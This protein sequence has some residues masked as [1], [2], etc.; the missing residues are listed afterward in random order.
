MKKIFLIMFVFFGFI[1]TACTETVLPVEVSASGILLQGSSGQGTASEPFVFDVELNESVSSDIMVSPVGVV[2]NLTFSFVKPQGNDFVPLQSNDLTGLSLNN[3]NNNF[4]FSVKAILEGS[5][6]VKISQDDIFVYIRVNVTTPE[7]PETPVDFSKELK[8]LAIGNS[9]SDDGM[10]Y[11]YQIANDYGVDNIVLGN[12]YIG[13]AELALHNTNAQEDKKAYTYRKNTTGSWVST[14]NTSILDG[15]LDEE[16]DIITIQQASGKSG[17]S[18]FFEP[19]LTQLLEYVHENKTNSKAKVYWHMT[20]AYQ[21]TS[22]HSE[23]P[24]Y[25]SDQMTMYN[26]IISTYR[27]AVEPKESIKGVIPAGTAIQNI[28]TSY[29]G[30][31]VTSDGYHLNSGVGRFTAGMTWFKA[32][33]GLSINNIQYRPAGVS[34]SDLEAIKE[35]VNQAVLKPFEVTNST[36]T[37]QSE[38]DLKNHTLVN[39]SLTYVL[40]YWVSDSGHNIFTTAANSVN[41]STHTVRLSKENLPVGSVLKIEPG[42]QYRINYFSSLSGPVT[43]NVRSSNITTPE[44]VIDSQ[45]WGNYEYVGINVAHT[46]AST[47]IS[48]TFV[49]VGNKLSIYAAPGATSPRTTDEENPNPVLNEFPIEYVLGYWFPSTHVINQTAAN[50]INFVASNRRY[51]KEELPIGTVLEIETGYQFRAVMFKNLDGELTDNVR[52]DNL[53][54]NV[55]IDAAFWGD[56]EYVGFNISPNTTTDVTAIVADVASKFKVKVPY[57]IQTPIPHVDQP[58]SFLSGYWFDNQTTINPGV[59]TFSKGFAASNALSKKSLEEF[60]QVTIAA[61]YQVR[62]VFFSYDNFGVYKVLFRTANFTGVKDLDDTFWGTYEYLGFNISSVPST[63][64]SSRLADLPDLI[65]FTTE[66]EEEPTPTFTHEDK[67]LEFI[68]GYWVDNATQ[69]TPGTDTFSRGFLASNVLSR[70]AVPLGTKITIETGYQIRIIF[71]TFSEL[72]GYKVVHRTANYSQEI[73]LT[74]PIYKEYQYI[75]FNISAVPTRSLADEVSS[76]ASRLTFTPFTDE[77]IPHVNGPLSFVSGFWN[78]GGTQIDSTSSNANQFIASNILSKE[79]FKLGTKLNIEANYQVRVVFLGYEFNKYYVILRTDNFTGTVV[80]DETFWSNYQ[81]VAFNISEVALGNISADVSNVSG[82]I[83]F[84]VP[85][86]PHVDEPLSFVSGYWFDNGTKP[87]PGTDPFSKGFA[88]S[89]I[90]SKASLEDF[91]KVTISSGY[92]VR[93]VF[94]S[95]DDQGGYKVLFR[96]ANQTGVK[97]LDDAFWGTYEYLGFNISSTPSSD[98][99]SRLAD[100]PALINFET[101]EPEPLYTHEDKAL[102]FTSGYWADNATQ[103]ILGTTDFAK[104]F[105]GSNV[106][107]RTAVPLGTKISIE[108]GY[109]VRLV[110]LTF[111]GDTGYK[112]VNRSNNYQGEF[113]LTQAFY[114]EHQYI[115]FNISAVPTRNLFDEVSTATTKINVT[116]FSDDVVNHVNKPIEFVVGF[117]DNAQIKVTSTATNSNQFIAS[118]VFSKDYFLINQKLVIEAGYQVRVIFLDYQFNQY[119]VLLRTDNFTGTVV[120]DE[121]FWSNYQYVAFNISEVALGNISADVSNVASKISFTE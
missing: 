18:E 97:I 2:R 48:E 104:G 75:A 3:D 98:L 113:V 26:A 116:Q 14:P 56:F 89:N 81:Y 44:I 36:H 41:F 79:Y 93:Y 1:I 68:S 118:N 73:M 92:Q 90:L 39:T 61:G 120:M 31:T 25:N 22:T 115:A 110:F 114:K 6:F 64:L 16:W 32:I 58:L 95:Y 100:L 46:G 67:P 101:E 80:M 103:L 85:V 10:Q 53:R 91:S 11:V 66:Q 105:L 50:H 30:D 99:S 60:T 88:A 8:V 37:E 42:Y 28:R 72:T 62:F 33:T 94:F 82:K 84:E 63:D 71:L 77:I 86:V 117:W 74:T 15:L 76:G 21:Q 5:Y 106:L 35:A 38:I 40:G 55:T 112:V 12:L 119:N 9:F 4:K 121:T 51:S 54:V 70:T 108:A 23:F 52:T 27:S 17:R 59:D 45:W 43:G 69:A 102:E 13:G 83:A 24:F 34:L 111:S 87:I 7:E 29:I 47:N 19:Y 49:A 20:W 57:V 78:T 107:S 109:Q 65:T 96:T